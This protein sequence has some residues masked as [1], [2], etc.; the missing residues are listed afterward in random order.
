MPDQ[1]F[2]MEAGGGLVDGGHLPAVDCRASGQIGNCSTGAH[3]GAQRRR[4]RSLQ[5]PEQM[6]AVPAQAAIVLMRRL[7]PPHANAIG[8]STLSAGEAVSPLG[9]HGACAAPQ[10]L[11]AWKRLARSSSPSCASRTTS[12]NP[13]GRPT[14]SSV[15]MRNSSGASR[16]NA[17]CPVPRP[18]AC[19][20]GRC[21]PAAK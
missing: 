13:S 18:P 21:W 10:S 20:S 16:P 9:R 5:R 19:C 1:L 3:E 7:K 17:C 15:C 4:Q 6:Q 2:R 8:R 11:P 12:G 14:P